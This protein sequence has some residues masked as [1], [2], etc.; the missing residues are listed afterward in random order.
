MDASYRG[1]SKETIGV[2]VRLRR[3]EIAV[4]VW[5]IFGGLRGSNQGAS[6]RGGSND[7]IGGRVRPRGPEILLSYCQH[8]LIA[9]V[10]DT[11]KQFFGGDI[12][13][14]DKIVPRCHWYWS[15]ITKKHKFIAG[16]N[17]TAENLFTGV[18]DAADKFFPSGNDTSDKT[19]LTIPA[20]LGLKMKT[21]QKINLQV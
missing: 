4:L 7:T 5:S 9:D 19:V 10:N 11:C 18:N 17:D 15:E 2:C 13:A 20:C 14:G 1:G 6:Y 12:D 3:P 8:C 16:V 21:K